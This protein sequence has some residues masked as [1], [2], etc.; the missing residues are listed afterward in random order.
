MDLVLEYIDDTFKITGFQWFDKCD[1][2]TFLGYY[3]LIICQV[4]V[5]TMAWYRIHMKDTA[6][7][8][9]HVHLFV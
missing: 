5:E 4:V 3:L 9:G 8:P 2:G 6:F 1:T 7:I